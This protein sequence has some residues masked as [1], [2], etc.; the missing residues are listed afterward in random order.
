MARY[1]WKAKEPSKSQAKSNQTV[2]EDMHSIVKWQS[3]TDFEIG[4]ELWFVAIQGK[5]T[6][7]IM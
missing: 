5:N 4:E 1:H 2:D 7:I 6:V 3:S